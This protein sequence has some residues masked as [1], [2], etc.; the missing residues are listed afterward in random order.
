MFGNLWLFY[1]TTVLLSSS[2]F[3]FLDCPTYFNY[4]LIMSSLFQSRAHYVI[5]LIESLDFLTFSNYSK[6][7]YIIPYF[8][9][10]RWRPVRHYKFVHGHSIDDR[11][12]DDSLP[13]TVTKIF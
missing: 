3:F 6:I 7:H 8:L 2:K 9:N 5:L 1:L 4:T 10:Q 13:I 11:R 12:A